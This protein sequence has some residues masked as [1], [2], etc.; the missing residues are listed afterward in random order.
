MVSATSNGEEA[1]VAFGGYNGRYS[2]E[3]RFF[4]PQNFFSRHFNVIPFFTSLT[5]STFFAGL[6]YE[7]KSEGQVTA[8]IS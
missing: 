8:K 6:H 7:D 1:L 5:F 2:N 3:V 4:L